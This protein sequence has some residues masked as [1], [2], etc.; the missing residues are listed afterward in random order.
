MVSSGVSGR[1]RVRSGPLRSGRP[2]LALGVLAVFAG[3]VEASPGTLAECDARIAAGDGGGVDDCWF[4]L[5]HTWPRG[6]DPV[7]E[8]LEQRLRRHPTDLAAR[9]WAGILAH[10]ESRPAEAEPLLMSAAE[11][12]RVQGLADGEVLARAELTIL[13]CYAGRDSG[14]DLA[15]LDVLAAQELRPE[16]RVWALSTAAACARKAHDHGRAIT[17]FEESRRL[18]LLLPPSFLGEQL[19][20]RVL[21]GL[22]CAYSDS[23]RHRESYAVFLEQ[24]RSPPR[25]VLQLAVLKHRLASE[26]VIMADEGEGSWPE[27]E[28]R[29]ADSL[30]ME[31]VLPDP[32]WP[33]N[34]TR[35]IDAAL[36]GPSAEALAQLDRAIDFWRTRSFWGVSVALRLRAKF[37]ADLDPSHPGSA[38]AVADESLALASDAGN[39]WEQGMTLLARAYVHRRAGQVQP[40]VS[41]ALGALEQLDTVRDAQLDRMEGAWTAAESSFAYELVAGWLLDPPGGGARPGDVELAFE[42]LERHRAR[43]LREALSR[44][45]VPLLPSG[46]LGR[47]RD[48]ALGEIARL[49]A[50][51]RSS[52]LA[53]GPRTRTLEELAEAERSEQSLRRELAE[54][55]PRKLLLDEDTPTLAAVQQALGKDQALLSFQT[56]RRQHHHDATYADGSSWL[57]VVSKEGAKA[58]RIP[59]ADVLRTRIDF[60]RELVGE[61]DGSDAEA[62][63]ALQR[64][65]LGP[66]LASLGGELRR[67]VI[68]PDGPL[69]RLPFE[70]LRADEGTPLGVRYAIATTPS[71]AL[72]LH[73][74][75][76]GQASARVTSPQ[77]WIL[78]SGAPST[79]PPLPP[80]PFAISEAQDVA[81]VLGDGA[82]TLLGDAASE[83][84][85]KSARL[86]AVRA[87]HFAAHAVV[88]EI[89]PDRSA[90]LLAPGSPDEDGRLEMRE[91][92]ELDLTDKLVVLASCRTAGG[93]AVE[94]EGPLSLARAF[95]QAGS[96]T[97]VGSLLPLRDGDSAALMRDLYRGLAGGL[98]I[99]RAVQEARARSIGAGAPTAAWAG[100][101]VFGDGDLVPFPAG[102]PRAALRSLWVAAVAL[103]AACL[104]LLLVRRGRSRHRAASPEAAAIH[105]RT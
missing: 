3:P 60:F 55:A 4:E 102:V 103:G 79:D 57:T 21:D 43:A 99:S 104:A 8:H 31:R 12:F 26:S 81:A 62:A 68:V 89:Q 54:N 1:P 75:E 51:L 7:R 84:V 93:A 39:R 82:R 52:A 49:E 80:L 76:R 24:S 77:A 85:L 2:L 59:D 88:D 72:W 17:L 61:R 35:L 23:G 96:A 42:L 41:D 70:A 97:V 14:P 66:A 32:N 48:A 56:W 29:I 71:A 100:V 22:G 53:A 27:A 6:I 69:H 18:L 20:Q 40:F 90:V 19:T 101:A 16:A 91:V 30:A 5:A 33:P 67:L 47:R 65:L 36:H 28:R 83:H 73:W 34:A 87:L 15:R 63:I 78:A 10:N 11:A 98:S 105:S 25:D 13:L 44:A 50:T 94:G 9:L 86:D 74:H 45:R 92:V 95:F 46:D 37:L 38:L 58:F 64:T